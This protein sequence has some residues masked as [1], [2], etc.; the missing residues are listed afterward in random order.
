MSKVHEVYGR[1]WDMLYLGRCTFDSNEP[2]KVAPT[3]VA[4]GTRYAVDPSERARYLQRDLSLFESEYPMCLHAYAVTRECAKRLSVLLQER[5]KSVGKDIDLI[6]AVGARA[7]VS[8]ILG[9]SPPYFVQVGR[10]ELPS[11]L[12]AIAD[13]DTAQRLAR[14]TLYHL[15]LRTRDPQSL[16]PYMDWPWFVD[17]M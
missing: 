12:T 17:S 2:A 7:G 14:S 1:D 16:A 10:Q 4:N 15:H 6:L 3:L 13:G 5:L 9:T 11:D 8:T